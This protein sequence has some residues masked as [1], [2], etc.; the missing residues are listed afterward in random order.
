MARKSYIDLLREVEEEMVKKDQLKA[1]R[2]LKRNSY[3][4]FRAISNQAGVTA[5]IRKKKKEEEK[6]T[7]GAKEKS[8]LLEVPTVE[9]AITKFKPKEEAW[10]NNFF[11]GV[12]GVGSSLAYGVTEGIGALG[13]VVKENLPSMLSNKVSTRKALEDYEATHGITPEKK[14]ELLNKY[15]KEYGD[16]NID[17]ATTK[18]AEQYSEKAEKLKLLGGLGQFQNPKE[19]E[20]LEKEV[21][22]IEYARDV[23]QEK[24]GKNPFT[25]DIFETMKGTLDFIGLGEAIEGVGDELATPFDQVEELGENTVGTSA[26]KFGQEHSFIGG[27]AQSVGGLIP[28]MVATA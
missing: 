8:P 7:F 25:D 24:R 14:E 2:P 16:G 10:Y 4:T 15:I 11:D 19:Y 28:A 6:I 23:L 17:V 21:A 13:T 20:Q 5:P 22:E 18:L 27:V 26:Q 1:P 9:E 12:K 3:D